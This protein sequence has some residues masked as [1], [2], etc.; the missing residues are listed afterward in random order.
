MKER[1]VCIPLYAP[2]IAA[3]AL[4]GTPGCRS[5]S[6]APPLAGQAAEVKAAPATLRTSVRGL[7]PLLSGIM[8]DTADRLRESHPT[9]EALV[10]SLEFKTDA[11]PLMLRTLTRPDPL[12]ALLGAWTYTLQLKG[13]FER[14][15]LGLAPETRTVMLGG[16][17]RLEDEVVGY[18][19]SLSA[20]PAFDRARRFVEAFAREHPLEDL[21]GRHTLEAQLA[22]LTAGRELGWGSSLAQ[23]QDDFDDAMARLDALGAALPKQIRWQAERVLVDVLGAPGAASLPA[24]LAALAVLAHNA[25][26]RLEGLPALMAGERQA[27]LAALRTETRAL[28]AWAADERLQLQVFV[29]SERGEVLERLASERSAV[30]AAIAAEREAALAGVRGERTAAMQDLERIGRDLVDRLALR[31]AQLLAVFAALTVLVITAFRFL[32]RRP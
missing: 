1:R 30:L 29:H 12:A 5:T 6:P 11:I 31:A 3:V 22:E 24:D 16:I 9:P 26:L 4:L 23:A 27:V 14:G 13:Y 18:A 25:S 28:E 19:R 20:G 10:V 32:G 21:A 2:L 7:I 15:D 17:G 8:E